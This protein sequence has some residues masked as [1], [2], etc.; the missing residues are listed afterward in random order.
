MSFEEPKRDPVTESNVD[1]TTN[2]VS[3]QG[4]HEIPTDEEMKTLRHVSGKI[5]LRCWLVAVV[6]LAERF[7][8]YGLSTPFQNYMQNGPNGTP[9][10][11]LSLKN[12]GATALSYFFQ[13][14]CYVTP[15]FGA[16]VADTYL[17]KYKAISVFAGIYAIG[18]FLIFVTSIPSITS[19]NTALGGYVSGIIILGIGTGGIKSNVSPL[20]ADQ[21]PKT[22]PVI[23]VLKS[24]ER[25][26]EDPAVTIQ[27]VFLFFYLM[28]NTGA[29][30]VMATTEL[31]Y[32]VGFWAAFLLPFCF[33]FV[34]IVALIIGRNMYVKVPVS[35]KVIAKA[36]KCTWIAIK[37]KFNYDAALPSNNPEAKYPWTDHFAEE[38]RR[39]ISACK[40]F[41]FYPFYW[42]VYGQMI[43]NFVS[44]AGQIELHG[45]PNDFLQVFDSIAIVVFIPVFESIL[46][47]F[48]RKFT[49]FRPITRIFFGFIVASSSMVYAAV[50]QHYIYKA[51]PCYDN[52]L[53]CKGFVGVPNH[54]HVAIQI[55]AYVLIAFSEILASVTGLEYAYTRAPA[56]MKS[57]ITSLFLLTNAVGSA[58][59]IAISS[60]SVNPKFVWSY[61]G[62]A[63]TSFIAGCLFWI[64]FQHYN[65]KEDEWNKLEYGN[66]QSEQNAIHPV[67][68][69]Q[70]SVKSLA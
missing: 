32:H 46:Y 49:P 11:A 19:Y 56:S 41:V 28:I 52:P 31:E 17:G 66:E 58:L 62:L 25:V 43:S 20:I 53:E 70:H 10:G 4:D 14:W 45:I 5:P 42:V 39:S 6:E 2:S 37:N 15:I 22:N 55:P 57:F 13:F 1:S 54:V 64:C 63:C 59:G 40:V 67:V 33:F 8:Y 48:I 3:V 7:S 50:L 68:S 65:K 9:P 61:T 26:I 36:F 27:N 23:K 24:G 12:Q 30:S 47:P 44:Q 60:T 29:L 18:S 35:D 69:F 38:V 34:G 21:I 51:G 16:W